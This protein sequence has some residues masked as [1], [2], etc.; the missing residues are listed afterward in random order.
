MTNL[1]N[2]Y[3][4]IHGKK[5]LFEYVDVDSFDN[6]DHKKCTQ[7][8]GFAFNG[9]KMILVNNTTNPNEFKPLGGSVEDGEHIDEALIREIK[10]ES[11]M[12][13]LDFKPLGYQ[14][15]TDEEGKDEPYYQ[16]RYYCKVEPYGPFLGDPDGDVT[17]VL[18]IDPADYKKYFDWGEIGDAL[19]DKALRI[20]NNLK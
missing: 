5:Y 7:T 19:M 8:I 12:K 13:V 20:K 15:V 4:N 10:E 9:D 18:E 6:I 16:L 17:E 3:T 1:K 2:T 14:I 11:N